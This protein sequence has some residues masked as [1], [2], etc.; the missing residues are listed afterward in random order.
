GR[1]NSVGAAHF[2]GVSG[3][4]ITF[5]RSLHYPTIRKTAAQNL[6][7]PASTLSGLSED[8][9]YLKCPPLEKQHRFFPHTTSICNDVTWYVC[10]VCHHAHPIKSVRP[11]YYCTS[12]NC[13][14]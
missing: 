12:R 8:K 4:Q 1:R 5:Y 6:C 10:N 9:A 14:N 3:K 7:Q 13:G 2:G 11:L